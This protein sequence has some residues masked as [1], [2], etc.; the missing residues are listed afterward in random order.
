[1]TGFEDGDSAAMP[2]CGNLIKIYEFRRRHSLFLFRVRERIEEI[3][4]N[5]RVL[6]N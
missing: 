4:E 1:M 6:V 2:A 5:F 3:L